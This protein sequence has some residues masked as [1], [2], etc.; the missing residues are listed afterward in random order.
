M[1]PF[2]DVFG[3]LRHEVDAVA[4]LHQRIDE[5]PADRRVVNLGV[6]GKAASALGITNGARL[7]DST[8]PAMTIGLAEP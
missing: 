7:I 5:A 8:P 6:A 2:G 3:G 4:L 1:K